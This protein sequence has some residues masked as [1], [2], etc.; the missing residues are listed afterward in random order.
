MGRAARPN[1]LEP[2]HPLRALGSNHR[3]QISVNFIDQPSQFRIFWEN[4]SMF[5]TPIATLAQSSV[6]MITYT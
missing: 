5:L 1:S 2:K 3:I 6:T 4:F